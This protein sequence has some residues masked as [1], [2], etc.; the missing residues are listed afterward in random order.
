[1]KIGIDI[2]NTIIDTI[3]ELKKYI[4]KYFNEYLHREVVF[5]CDGYS[6]K[7]LCSWS[8]E[9]M[10]DFCEKYLEEAVSSAKVFPNAKEVINELKQKGHYICF[11]T[12]RRNW[13]YKDPYKLTKEYLDIN[14]ISYDDIVVNC[15]DKLS[16]CL[17]NDIDVMIDDEPENIKSVSTKIPVIVLNADHNKDIVG[18][19]IIRVDNWKKIRDFLNN[20]F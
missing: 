16:F 20:N 10:L 3:P 13:E 17:E 8:N 4:K 6:T 1:M 19:N 9:E 18:D 15:I 14:G 12:A 2:D 7:N 5:N 11:I